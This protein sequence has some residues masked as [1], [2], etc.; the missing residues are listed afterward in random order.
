MSD[1]LQDRIAVE[2]GGF[3]YQFRIPT[4]TYDLQVGYKAADVRA[5]AYPE[6]QGILGA[7]DF[8]AVNFSRCCACLELYLAAA[9][10]LWPYGYDF[11]TPLSEVDMTRLP[12]V[13]FTKFPV[14]AADAVVEVGQAF[15]DRY[16]Q[17]RSER[18]A[19]RS[20]GAKAVAGGEN[21][22]SP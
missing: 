18:R 4:I 6:S 17:F 10:T 8:Q 13:D 1:V 20:A 16:A 2:V 21:P 12:A 11:D 7:I 3:T 9:D 15:Q 22:G 5:R 14:S 19:S